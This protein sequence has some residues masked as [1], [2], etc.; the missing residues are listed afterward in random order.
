LRFTNKEFRN[1]LFGSPKG[2]TTQDN[3]LDNQENHPIQS[4]GD[5]SGVLK[6]KEQYKP[7]TNAKT[8]GYMISYPLS[9]CAFSGSFAHTECFSIKTTTSKLAGN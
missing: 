6:K 4:R 1:D 3:L 7:L 5:G 2:P 8:A 9:W